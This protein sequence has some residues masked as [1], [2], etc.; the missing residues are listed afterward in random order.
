MNE[1]KIDNGKVSAFSYVRV[2]RTHACECGAQLELELDIPEGVDLKGALKIN[3]Q[4][5]KCGK[6]IVIPYGYHYV[7]GFRLLTKSLQ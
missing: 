3:G 1:I 4:C 6:D 5:P 2:K 7:E